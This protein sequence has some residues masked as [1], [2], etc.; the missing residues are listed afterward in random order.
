MANQIFTRTDGKDEFRWFLSQDGERVLIEAK[1]ANA[2]VPAAEVSVLEAKLT[3]KMCSW[4]DSPPS[5][6]KTTGWIITSSR[7]GCPG[8]PGWTT[9]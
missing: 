8:C 5:P 3:M 1:Y 4:Q 6:T 7:C 9:W 2:W